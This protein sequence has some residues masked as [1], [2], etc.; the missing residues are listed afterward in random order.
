[1]VIID[2][3]KF[4]MNVNM[5]GKE[6]ME[7]RKSKKLSKKTKRALPYLLFSFAMILVLIVMINSFWKEPPKYSEPPF[8]NWYRFNYFNMQESSWN[9]IAKT[10]FLYFAPFIVIMICL[11][12]L[13]HGV[14]FLVIKR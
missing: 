11:A 4:R 13:F 12:W 5:N 7:Y 8:A 14:G 9:S 3:G 1:M 2:E 6:F 10:T